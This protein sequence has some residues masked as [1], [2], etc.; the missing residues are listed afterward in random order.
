MYC[1]VKLKGTGAASVQ[2]PFALA[3]PSMPAGARSPA[4]VAELPVKQ[5]SHSFASPL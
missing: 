1:G 3:A 2:A 4:S 5:L